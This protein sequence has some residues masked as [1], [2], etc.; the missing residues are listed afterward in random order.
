MLGDVAAVIAA[1]SG[2][3]IAVGGVIRSAR[4]QSDI[5]DVRAE[6]TTAN[7]Q[8]LAALADAVEGRRIKEDVDHADRT[9]HEQEY[10]DALSKPGDESRRARMGD[11]SPGPPR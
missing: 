1:L 4:L 6:V 11:A 10:V 9:T 5:A 2:L 3:T 7:G 8:T